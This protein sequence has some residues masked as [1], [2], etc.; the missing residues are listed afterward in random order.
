MMVR[1]AQTKDATDIAKLIARALAAENTGADSTAA[2]KSGI[3]RNLV[4]RRLARW[5]VLVSEHE[6][7][8]VGTAA[9]EANRVRMVFVDPARHRQ[10]IGSALLTSLS[11]LARRNKLS[12]LEVFSAPGAVQFYTSHGYLPVGNFTDRGQTTLLMRATH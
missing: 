12:A 5:H 8:I 4:I 2:L 3:S 11:E 7:T 1:R 9:L 10:G 6:G